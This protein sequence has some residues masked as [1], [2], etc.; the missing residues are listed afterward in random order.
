V[1]CLAVFC[2]LS[3]A[4]IESQS[5]LSEQ[6]SGVRLG[7]TDT[8]GVPGS[9]TPLSDLSSLSAD[10]CSHSQG[11]FVSSVT[12]CGA[13]QTLE[14]AQSIFWSHVV[15]GPLVSFAYFYA[16][17]SSFVALLLR[18]FVS[19]LAARYVQFYYSHASNWSSML[20]VLH[21]SRD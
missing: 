7:K 19:F 12:L 4:S 13:L 17:V 1:E 9:S 16:I 21:Q 3:A 8:L 18:C 2:P 5:S 11:K 14:L 20:G 10:P 6:F 15:K